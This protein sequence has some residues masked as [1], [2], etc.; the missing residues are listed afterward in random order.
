MVF[1]NLPNKEAYFRKTGNGGEYKLSPFAVPVPNESLTL[2]GLLCTA[3]HR[4]GYYHDTEY[5]KERIVLHFTAGELSGDMGMLTRQD[6][7]V[8]VPF[9][10][11]RDGTIYQLYS[12]KFWSGNLGGDAVGN[13]GNAQD[14]RTI[15]IE[16]SNFGPMDLAS[17]TLRMTYGDFSAYCTLAQTDSYQKLPVP[18]RGKSYY[19]TH[20][21]AQ[22]DSLIVLLR[23]LTTQYAIPRQFM[24]EPKRYL[25]TPDVLTFKGIVSHINYR[26]DG[27]W[28]LGPA[29]NWARVMTGVQAPA[30]VPA[31][32]RDVEFIEGPVLLSED[33]M[34]PLLPQPKSAALEDEPYDDAESVP[35]TAPEPEAETA[36]PGNVYA[37]IV[38]VDSYSSDVI[39]QNSVR[40]PALRGCVHDAQAIKT[41]LENSPT[42]QADTVLLTNEA[43]SKSAIVNAFQNH[44]G[45]AKAGDVALFYFSG[46]GTQEYADKTV[47]TGETDGRLECLAC[48]YDS[49]TA[50]NFL[51]ADKELRYL[52]GQL[53]AGKPAAERPQIVAI[54]DCCH[55]G[56][57]TRNGELISTAFADVVEKRIPFSFQQ[58]AWNQFIFGQT[59]TEDTVRQQGVALAIPEGTHVQLSACES[60][61]SALEVSGEGVF[62]KTLLNVLRQAGGPISYYSLRSR[63][64]QYL[65]NVF[66]QRPRIYVANGDDAL[67]Y[68]NFLNQPGQANALT[69]GEIV[70]VPGANGRVGSWL[71]NRGAIHGITPELAAFTVTNPHDSSVTYQASVD[72]VQVDHTYLTFDRVAPID[73]NVT[74]QAAIPGLMARPIAV[75]VNHQDG[76]PEEQKK[77]MDGLTNQ[78]IGYIVLQDDESQ[79]DYVVQNRDGRYYITLP[80]DPFRPLTQP[81]DAGSDTTSLQLADQ[82]RHL[83]Q[84]AFLESLT[85]TGT[86]ALPGTSLQV[87][88]TR[89][90][91][92]G[93][94][95]PILNTDGS[96]PIA[97]ERGTDDVWRSTFRVKVTNPT[98]VKLY[99]AVLYLDTEFQS[100]LGFLNPTT[101]LLEPGNAVYLG[102]NG[103]DVIK[104][105]LPAVMQAYNWSS[106]I[107]HLKL[108]V[109]TDEFDVQALALASLPEPPLPGQP[110]ETINRGGLETDERAVVL[111]G[112][113][114]QQYTL[115]LINPDINRI[116][117]ALLDAML[118]DLQTAPF[119]LGLYFDTTTGADWKT[120]YILKPEIDVVGPH[121]TSLDERGFIDDLKLD[122]ANAVA[123]KLRNRHYEAVIKQFPDRI[124]MVSEGDSWFQHPLVTD[125]IDH[126][127]RVYAIHCVAAAGDTLRNIQRMG[128]YLDDITAQKPAFF[129]L[130]GGGND[131][132]G[133]QFRTYLQ[134]NPDMSQPVGENPRRFLKDELFAELDSLRDIY[135]TVFSLLQTSHPDLHILVH[136]YD[137]IIP[138]SATNK[139]WLGRYMIEKGIDRQEDR[140]AVIS[141]I[142]TEFNNRM[143]SVAASFPNVSYINALNTVRPNQWYDEI[144]PNG[145]GFQQVAMKFMKRINEVV[146]AM[147]TPT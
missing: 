70:Y 90:E 65:R 124:R 37:L 120:D 60:D 101:Y 146:A 122:L 102:I 45:K 93:T 76:S 94:E 51:L 14:K 104:S 25:T 30:F 71:L 86:N 49:Q 103:K 63:V 98:P 105:R 116:N 24:P 144:H 134:D 118:T 56:D 5:A 82:L 10:I 6:Y 54:F 85:N 80:N 97:Y 142:L 125:I 83:S 17:D 73:Q 20:T 137:Y 7:H 135:Q 40:F 126:L 43:A 35:V 147:P 13:A 44:L 99:C 113:C 3:A 66:D 27:K 107:E 87:V 33:A 42:G 111:K 139:G 92:D 19:A 4:S 115:Q 100:F 11:A 140:Q 109:S 130:S 79:A 26:K 136:G 96:I 119:A 39:L 78:I 84:W 59:I 1:T 8:S 121:A 110:K 138:L 34:I 89:L 145:D 131:I 112:W 52:I 21:D 61:E 106:R 95:K 72:T 77:L 114:T 55:S 64:R 117:G 132:L 58:R 46:H 28:D 123:R 12:S 68:A 129:L 32:N 88:F 69:T 47:W 2:N 75:C 67:L 31:Q 18:F 22:Y 50:D 23:Y 62:T 127:G 143:K 9:V 91:A 15:G 141:L 74:Y 108:I 133:T 53:D 48:Y 41:Y 81:V 57:N 128:E 16:L 38:G 36:S 29:F